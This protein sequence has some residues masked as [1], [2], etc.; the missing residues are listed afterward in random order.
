MF[1][2]FSFL[3]WWTINF[4]PQN[5]NQSETIIGENKLSV[6]LYE[7]YKRTPESI[8]KDISWLSDTTLHNLSEFKLQLLVQ[9]FWQNWDQV[10]WNDITMSMWF[11]HQ[12]KSW[13]GMQISLLLKF[14]SLS[15]L[16][17]V[18]VPDNWV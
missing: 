10:Q 2:S 8:A 18:H 6:E 11:L 5:I 9:A 15:F 7:K 4:L 16:K 12:L 1:L 3:F 17:R 14:K 13:R